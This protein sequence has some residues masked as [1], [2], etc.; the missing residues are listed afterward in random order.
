MADTDHTT[1][2]GPPFGPDPAPGGP[3]DGGDSGPGLD[4]GV[5]GERPAPS[6]FTRRQVLTM[7]GAAPSKRASAC[8]SGT[9]GVGTI[10]GAA[11][12]ADGADSRSPQKTTLA[13][14]TAHKAK[15][16]RRTPHLLCELVTMR[17]L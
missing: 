4:E 13:P 1:P 14:A 17:G 6:R 3:G 2:L 12:P 11:V 16:P 15:V 10:T 5:P 8:A 9:R 7:A